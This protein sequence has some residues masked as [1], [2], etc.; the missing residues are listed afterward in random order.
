[1]TAKPVIEVKNVHKEFYLPH[2]KSDSIKDSIVHIFD[3]KDKGADYYKALKGISFDVKEGE[4]LGIVGRNG[5]GKSTLLKI[6]SNIYVPTSG[7]VRHFGKLVPFIELGVGFKA[8]LTGRENVYLNGALLG[9]SKKEMDERYDEIV[10][11]SELEKFMDQKLKNYSSGMKVRLAFS[12]ATHA[13]ADIL[14]LDEVLAVGDADFQRKCYDYFKSLK[15][16]KKTI[17]FVTHSMGAV[18]EY[19]DRAI[20]IQDGKITHEGSP[21][22][23]ADE[24]LKMFNKP[25]D[26]KNEK[27]GK[28]WGNQDV[29]IDT[30]KVDVNKDTIIVD[31]TLRAGQAPPESDVKFGFRIK[32]S[33]GKVIAGANNLNVG[34][35]T[36]MTFKS[37]EVKNLVFTMPNIFGSAIYHLSA[38]VN[39]MDG[40]TTCD[41]WEDVATFSNTKDNVHYPVVCPAELTVKD[42]A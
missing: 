38:T 37:G 25:S 40:I 42:N 11:F 9:F 33:Q 14:L 13:D 29:V 24:Y 22:D 30:L 28:R 5:S 27:S 8:E 7:H 41:N 21:D 17:I 12:V 3:K 20:L 10:A 35:A 32:D 31:A 19:C 2:H 15:Q 4:F 36:H 18:R 1:M 34:G 39:L 16:Q 6:L 23:V 26:N